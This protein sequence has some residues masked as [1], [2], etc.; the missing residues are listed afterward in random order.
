[1]ARVDGVDPCVLEAQPE[2]KGLTLTLRVQ[3][4]IR[5]LGRAGNHVG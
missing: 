3:R 2:S 5:T 4:G 1:V